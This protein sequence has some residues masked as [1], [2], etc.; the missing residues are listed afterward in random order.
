M[1]PTLEEGAGVDAGGCVP[2]DEHLVPGTA[3]LAAEEVVEADLV[4]RGGRRVGG[5]VAA[6]TVDAAVG[7]GDHHRG[8]PADVVADAAFH[9]LVARIRR[10]VGG[11]DGVEVVGDARAGHVDPE[12]SRPAEHMQQHAPGTV[13]AARL[14]KSVHRVG[15]LL[16]LGTVGLGELVEVPVRVERGSDGG[17]TQGTRHDHSPRFL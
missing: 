12:P 8:V 4:E 2:L 16:H 11:R 6:E 5:E 13:D 15:P 14:Q 10:L 17:G 1:E 3:V 7:T 9:R